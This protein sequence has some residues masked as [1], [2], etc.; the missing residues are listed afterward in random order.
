[1]TTGRDGWC[2]DCSSRCSRAF[3]RGAVQALL[4][5]LRRKRAAEMPT[6]NRVKQQNMV[7]E[8]E[9]SRRLGDLER[10][11]LARLADQEL[12]LRALQQ[13]AIPG[14]GVKLVIFRVRRKASRIPA[15]IRRR[16]RQR[17]R[18]WRVARERKVVPSVESARRAAI[19]G[20]Y[21][22]ASGNVSHAPGSGSSERPPQ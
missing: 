6:T 5:A 17:R 22:D 12:Q 20:R 16:V 8:S 9:I 11:V 15:S 1:M 7:S 21:V 14:G 4:S 13:G 3:R 19:V 10:V 2:D 18:D